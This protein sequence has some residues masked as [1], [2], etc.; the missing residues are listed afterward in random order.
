[1]YCDCTLIIGCSFRWGIIL[2]KVAQ[3]RVGMDSLQKRLQDNIWQ[4]VGVVVAVVGLFFNALAFP[5]IA[6][7]LIGIIV[8]LF[9]VMG[10]IVL[11]KTIKPQEEKTQVSTTPVKPLQ[12]DSNSIGLAPPLINIHHPLTTTQQTEMQFIEEGNRR[13]LQ[14]ND[15][16]AKSSYERASILNPGNSLPYYYLGN[17]WYKGGHYDEAL[18]SYQRAIERDRLDARA[19]Y[20]KGMTL[21]CLGRGSE[22][23]KAYKQA[24]ANHSSIAFMDKSPV[25]DINFD[26]VKIYYKVKSMIGWAILIG[27]VILGLVANLFPTKANQTSAI[28]QVVAIAE[29]IF[30]I[31][32]WLFIKISRMRLH[33]EI[34][35]SEDKKK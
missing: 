3:R 4:F 27:V 25:N 9:L 22:A 31:L 23:N 12:I 6:T 15:I 24:I 34:P 2:L 28:F 33:I 21:E 7:R 32:V 19:Y 1:M 18:G 29:V 14:G 20:R 16:G 35:P 8:V 10:I 5:D 11:S 26:F 30:F 13:Y 17:V